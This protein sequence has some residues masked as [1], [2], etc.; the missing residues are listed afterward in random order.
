MLENGDNAGTVRLAK[1]H[2]MIS[3]HDGLGIAE[4]GSVCLLVWQA[5]VELQRFERQRA[6]LQS[7]VERYPRRAGFVCVIEP[8]APAPSSAFRKASISL[9][10]SH[11]DKLRCVI[12]VIEGTSFRTAATRSVMSGMVMLMPRQRFEFQIVATVDG[13]GPLLERHCDNVSTQSLVAAHRALRDG[14]TSSPSRFPNAR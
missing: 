12:G 14:L 5:P 9:L 4:V 1:T 8:S 11:G 2:R 13:A 3:T 7:V 10:T 6:A